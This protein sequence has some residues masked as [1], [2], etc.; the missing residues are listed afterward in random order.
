MTTIASG[1]AGGGERGPGK[2]K[3]V[4]PPAAA[5]G[6][7]SAAKGRRPVREA[8]RIEP[9]LLSVKQAAAFLNVSDRTLWTLSH[10]G[11]ISP[12]KIGRKVLYRRTDLERYV[13]SLGAR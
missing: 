10:G 9:A 6:V 13:A 2:R 11:P 3:G 5:E 4:R 1:A 12:V 8:E 7:P